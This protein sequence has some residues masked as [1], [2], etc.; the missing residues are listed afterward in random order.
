MSH[1]HFHD[2]LIR[3]NPW[4][5]PRWFTI[6]WCIPLGRRASGSRRIMIALESENQEAAFS[7]LLLY[8]FER[9][10]IWPANMQQIEAKLPWFYR[11]IYTCFFL[12]RQDAPLGISIQCPLF[13][14][15]EIHAA[16]WCFLV[17]N[18]NSVFSSIINEIIF[19]PL[20]S[21]NRGS[22]WTAEICNWKGIRRIVMKLMVIFFN[23]PGGKILEWSVIYIYGFQIV[24]ETIM[25]PIKIY[26]RQD[27]LFQKYSSNNLITLQSINL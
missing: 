3:P 13:G 27:K 17:K 11:R 6:P 26:R 14:E 21:L 10:K 5:S 16:K 8:A 23:R 22:W 12:R 19:N 25:S 24:S 2:F 1:C 9:E 4:K 15:S 20:L 18:V 7:R